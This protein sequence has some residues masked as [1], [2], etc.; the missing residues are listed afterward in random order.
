MLKLRLHAINND[1]VQTVQPNKQTASIHYINRKTIQINTQDGSRRTGGTGGMGRGWVLHLRSI[2]IVGPQHPNAPAWSVPA[3]N[4]CVSFLHRGNVTENAAES[5]WLPSNRGEL[6][7]TF[8]RKG[9]SGLGASFGISWTGVWSSA[10]LAVVD[11]RPPK[12]ARS[13]QAAGCWIWSVIGGSEKSRLSLVATELVVEKLGWSLMWGNSLR[14]MRTRGAH[15]ATPVSADDETGPRPKP[16]L[17]AWPPPIT[18]EFTSSL[19]K[20]KQNLQSSASTACQ[21]MC[22]N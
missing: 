12:D 18:D 14:S 5:A 13:L 11:K 22:Y 8:G 19:C 2:V 4:F 20:Y 17:T 16:V 7:G 10:L 3:K 21:N 1:A 15:S 6:G 9:V